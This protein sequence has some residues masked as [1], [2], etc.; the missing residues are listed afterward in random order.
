MSDSI[1]YTV[2]II[3]VIILLGGIILGTT[4]NNPKKSFENHYVE[5][6]EKKAATSWTWKAIGFIT[7]A[8]VLFMLNLPLNNILRNIPHMTLIALVCL[9]ALFSSVISVR[10]YSTI[11]GIT[12]LVIISLVVLITL[13]FFVGGY[14]LGH[15]Y[16]H[17]I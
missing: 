17:M 3:I 6:K 12:V 15:S 1:F 4:Y 9:G 10:I 7:S 8:L 16:R 2:V 13:L 14:A 5:I 11:F